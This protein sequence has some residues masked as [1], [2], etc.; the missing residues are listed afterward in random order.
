MNIRVVGVASAIE[1]IKR[2]GKMYEEKL[3]KVIPEAA[4]NI[5]REAKHLAPIRTG[6]LR[7]S[8]QAELPER[9]RAY[10]KAYAPYAHFVEYGTSKMKARPYMRPAVEKE[11]TRL[12]RLK[13]L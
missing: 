2:K 4:L 11:R 9:L 12:K 13:L 3:A 6:N 5:Q 8:I 1:A 10:V 7:N